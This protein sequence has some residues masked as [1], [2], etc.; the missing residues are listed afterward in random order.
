MSG[1]TKVVNLGSFGSLTI[2]EAAGLFNVVGKLSMASG[3]SIPGDVS[4]SISLDLQVKGQGAVDAI[5]ALEE[6]SHPNLLALLTA[7]QAIFDTAVA[8]V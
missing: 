7:I 3:G 5:I 1:F 2:S 6:K 8:L 4:G